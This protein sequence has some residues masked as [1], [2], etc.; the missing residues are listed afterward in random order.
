MKLIISVKGNSWI[1]AVVNTELLEKFWGN[2]QDYYKSYTYP[3]HH[4]WFGFDENERANVFKI[5]VCYFSR[6]EISEYKLQFSNGRHRT[7]WLLENNAQ[8]IPIAILDSCYEMAVE[9][10]LIVRKLKNRSTF[11]LG[12]ELTEIDYE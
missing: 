9:S 8:E 6:F 12:F 1:P 11:E 4:K 7:R 2:D 10:G 3:P 5:G